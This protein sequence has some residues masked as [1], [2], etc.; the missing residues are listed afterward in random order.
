[1]IYISFLKEHNNVYLCSFY[2]QNYTQG[3]V[4]NE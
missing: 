3:G 4:I 2:M 1:M